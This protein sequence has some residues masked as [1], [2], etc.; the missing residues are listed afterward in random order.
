MITRDQT[1]FKFNVFLITFILLTRATVSTVFSSTEAWNL[2]EPL[3][4]QLASHTFHHYNNRLYI[5]GGATTSVIPTNIFTQLVD[6]G[7]LSSWENSTPPPST[8]WHS[9]VLKESSIYIL[10]GA[11]FPPTTS[12]N[13]V[14]KGSIENS[15]IPSWTPLTPL[16]K[17]LSQGAAVVIGNKLYFAGGDTNGILS[18]TVYVTQ[19]N[20]DGTIGSW[21]I[22]GQLPR[23]LNG[24]GMVTNG[25]DIYI[26]GGNT[27]TGFT[28]KTY[29]STVN[30]D[31]TLGSWEETTSLPNPTYRAGTIIVGSRIFSIGGLT[32]N[33]SDKV[34]TVEI[35]SNGTLGSWTEETNK[36]P[37]PVCCGATTT[38]GSYLYLS[39]GYNGSYLNTVYYAKLDT[40]APPPPSILNV[41][42]FSQNVSPWGPSEYD[43][44]IS[45]G[46]TNPTMDRWGCAVTSAAMVLRYHGMTEMVDGTPID[47]A[48]L[49]N[50]LKNNKGYI[51]GKDKSGSYSYISWP[52]ISRLT[53]QLYSA[54]KSSIKLMHKRVYPS[55]ETTTL[56][57]EDLTVRKMPNILYVNNA[58][59]SGHFIVAKGVSNNTYAI[60]DPEWNYSHLTS[61]N[62]TYMQVDRY[63]PSQTNLSYI[64]L[65]VNPNIEI[66]VEAPN[67]QKTGK[68]IELNGEAQTYNQ[69]PNA[70]Y[71]FEG[72]ISNPNEQGT[73]ESLGTGTNTF[74][75]PEPENGIYKITL[76]SK[77][78]SD[79]FLNVSLFTT[80]GDNDLFQKLGTTGPGNADTLELNYSQ[81]VLAEPE[82]IVT[83]S[84]TINDIRE[85]QNLKWINKYIAE[86]LV[87]IIKSA[88]K[89]YSAGKKK[90]MLLKLAG[91]E[92][93]IKQF[94]SKG[95][96]KQAY[97]VLKY[98]VDYLQGHL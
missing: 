22:A 48:S 6:N 1:L 97:D 68:I 17:A 66:L 67:G 39:G 42:F 61:F 94:K 57:N 87:L 88:E 11:T 91:F 38:N 33:Y 34:Y 73:V 26:I 70:T 18:Q 76:T 64:M 30:S 10:G 82:K 31:G 52:A 20:N 71:A 25:N 47:P 86:G 65:I 28:N 90:L 23:G 14:S 41:P 27:T 80:E 2:A 54:G 4:N 9:S 78:V 16:P 84:S 95:I 5:L 59:T 93:V 8:F 63:I 43:H 89:D 35:Q 60:N 92:L 49:N 85:A 53:E 15:S 21:S 44:S 75:L 46:F 51:T 45:L 12:L 13:F 37:Q 96:S 79:Y 56:L 62:N 69:V 40:P 19:T 98:D 50:W 58:D 3:P 36:L 32:P 24:F 83:F 81:D 77:E 7:N 74:L 55:P 72:P 29:K